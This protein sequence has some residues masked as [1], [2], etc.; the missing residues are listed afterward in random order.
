MK[1]PT[2]ILGVVGTGLVALI[3]SCGAWIFHANADLSSNKAEHQYI[4]EKQI[5]FESNMGDA[6]KKLDKRLDRIESK[7][8]NLKGVRE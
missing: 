1:I 8:D 3:L 2:W 6:L 5:G 4:T 7:I